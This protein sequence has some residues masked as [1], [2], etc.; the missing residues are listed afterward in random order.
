MEMIDFL[1]PSCSSELSAGSNYSG[2]EIKCP[3]CEGLMIVPDTWASNHQNE[4]GELMDFKKRWNKVES[5][6]RFLR[7]SY[8]ISGRIS[9]R[10]KVEILLKMEEGRDALEII[11]EDFP[12][13]L[14]KRGEFVHEEV[15]KKGCLGTF[16]FLLVAGGLL[17]AG[18]NLLF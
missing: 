2:T 6:L 15:Q 4:I 8:E 9:E 16:L 14:V 12:E 10:A 5:A 1:C 7:D 17:V 11:T 3:H 18:V 13:Y